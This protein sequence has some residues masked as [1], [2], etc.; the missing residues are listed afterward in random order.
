MTS[1][2][3]NSHVNKK[4]QSSFRNKY[5]RLKKKCKTL[6]LV[7]LVSSEIENSINKLERLHYNKDIS[8]NRYRIELFGWQK[9]QKTLLSNLDLILSSLKDEEIDKS[10]YRYKAK[11]NITLDNIED[12]KGYELLQRLGYYNKDSNS[13]GVVKDHRLSIK[14][15]ITLKIPPNYLGNI[16]NCEFLT[17]K[18]N[19]TKSSNNSILLEEFCKLTN[20]PL[21]ERK[22]SSS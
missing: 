16:N 7:H 4:Y 20:F 5:T 2:Y 3:I 12:I 8:N 19:I 18:D 11:F 13:K 17:Y 6:S 15:G 10:S 14:T 21:P 9:A 22:H 1:L